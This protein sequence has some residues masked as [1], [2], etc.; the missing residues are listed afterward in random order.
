MRRS[1]FALFLL[2]ACQM[3]APADGPT[4]STA[5]MAG[6][7]IAVS[8]LDA[9]PTSASGAT[10]ATAQMPGAEAPPTVTKA[11][12]ATPHPKPRPTNLAA[13]PVSSVAPQA[14]S[15][16]AAEPEAPKTAEQV[17]C[18]KTGGQWGA[19]GDTGT[20]I[21]QK[22][23]RDAGKLCRKKGDCQGVCLARSGNL[24]AFHAALWLQ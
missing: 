2:A 7:D 13:T 15:E 3:T 20:F 9:A 8:T 4:A 14:S 21:C 10:A 5:G 19:A 24:L 12:P 23:T 18:E 22:K 1:L 16:P 6:G 11:T 17:L